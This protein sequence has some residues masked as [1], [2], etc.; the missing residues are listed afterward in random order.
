MVQFEIGQVA[1]IGSVNLSHSQT[2]RITKR[3]SSCIARN[4]HRRS[5]WEES[6]LPKQILKSERERSQLKRERVTTDSIESKRVN[7]V[8]RDDLTIHFH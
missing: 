7:K 8:C 2:C 1:M 3:F 6:S 4:F 5:R